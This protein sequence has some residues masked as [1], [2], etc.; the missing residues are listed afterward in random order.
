VSNSAI[1]SG[2]AVRVDDNPLDCDDAATRA[3]LAT[4]EERGVAL[5]HDCEDVG[6]DADAR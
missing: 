2:H 6:T 4:L 5:T 1:G 3:D